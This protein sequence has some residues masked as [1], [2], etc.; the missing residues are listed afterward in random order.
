MRLIAAEHQLVPNVF[1]YSFAVTAS[2]I[3]AVVSRK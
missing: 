3:S 2:E 1:I